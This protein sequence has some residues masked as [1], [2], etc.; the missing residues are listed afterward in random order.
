M[1]FLRKF[2]PMN[3]LRFLYV[4]GLL[5]LDTLVERL[6]YE[7]LDG[8]SWMVVCYEWANYL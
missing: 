8:F 6:D 2:A 7:L 4:G 3:F 1:G 5:R